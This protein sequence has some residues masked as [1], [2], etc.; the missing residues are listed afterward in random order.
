MLAQAMAERFPY[1]IADFG[2]RRLSA[3]LLLRQDIPYCRENR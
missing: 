2:G 3:D 1:E